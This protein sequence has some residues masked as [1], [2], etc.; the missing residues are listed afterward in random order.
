MKRRGRRRS[1]FCQWQRVL[2]TYVIVT[3]TLCEDNYMWSWFHSFFF[4]FLSV[5]VQQNIL[6]PSSSSPHHGFLHLSL[7]LKQLD[8]FSPTW[9]NFMEQIHSNSPLNKDAPHHSSWSKLPRKEFW[10]SRCSNSLFLGLARSFRDP[11]EW[12]FWFRRS[13]REINATFWRFPSSANVVG[14]FATG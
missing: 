14:C 13:W 3:L 7:A 2:N 8:L 12:N 10:F 4:Q 11:H 9:Q 6:I 1:P 5:T